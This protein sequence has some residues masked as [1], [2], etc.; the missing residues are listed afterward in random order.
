MDLPPFNVMPFFILL[1]PIT[2]KQF[3][4]LIWKTI[5][6]VDYHHLYMLGIRSVTGV[7]IFLYFLL[8]IYG[9]NIF[10]RYLLNRT[11]ILN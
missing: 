8:D 3:L 4:R 11:P 2:V 6:Q 5:I 7:L 1:I 9:I 10:I